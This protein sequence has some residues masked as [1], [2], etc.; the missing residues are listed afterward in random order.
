[1]AS[2]PKAPG[3]RLFVLALGL[4]V[5]FVIGFVMLLSRLPVD[6]ALSNFS[7][8][9]LKLGQ[10]SGNGF[11]FYEVLPDQT[12]ARRPRIVEPVQPEVLQGTV[13]PPA[14]RI[15]PGNA[16]TLSARSLAAESYAEIPASSIGQESYIL[17]AGI[18]RNARDAEKA[19]AGLLLLG[20]KPRIELRQA[21]DGSIRH[22]VRIGPLMNRANVDA[23][24]S[25]L[26]SGGINYTLFRIAG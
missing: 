26:Q 25:R 12:V 14:T 9:D 4:L 23:A 2:T 10:S 5:G 3:N 17:Q 20:L 1:M 21:S 11:Q 18:Y 19:R 6:G 13:I 7:A 16:Q 22:H 15:V 8:R 24:K